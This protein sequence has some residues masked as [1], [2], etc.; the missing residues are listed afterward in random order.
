MNN[1]VIITDSN[2][3]EEVILSL[4]ESYNKIKDV[5]AKEYKNVEVI[6]ESETWSGLCSQS[7]YNKYTELNRNYDLVLYS[8]DLYIKFLEKTLEDYRRLDEEISKNADE[9][10]TNLDVNS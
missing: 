7:V 6:N 10:S 1:K 4:K 5:V 3:F 2:K 8:L 9:M